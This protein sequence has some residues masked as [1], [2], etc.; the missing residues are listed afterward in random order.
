M[1]KRLNLKPR[2]KVNIRLERGEII[3]TPM[4]K[5]CVICE[6]TDG[7]KLLNSQHIC[8]NCVESIVGTWMKHRYGFEDKSNGKD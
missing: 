3:I 2:D 4:K 8:M 1:Q 6:S 7:L 5:K